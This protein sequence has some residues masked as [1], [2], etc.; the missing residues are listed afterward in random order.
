MVAEL[1]IYR[2]NLARDLCDIISSLGDED[3]DLKIKLIR[4]RLEEVVSDLGNDEAQTMFQNIKVYF[5]VT[6][7]Y[8]EENA[9][10]S[11]YEP[12][13]EAILE[14]I[15]LGRLVSLLIKKSHDLTEEEKRVI[16]STL[17]D[18]G[19]SCEIIRE[20][21]SQNIERY[22][23]DEIGLNR[24]NHTD[25][26]DYRNHNANVEYTSNISNNEQLMNVDA[27]CL[28]VVSNLSDES[29][30]FLAARSLEFLNM[31]IQ[32]FSAI[33]DFFSYY[34]IVQ[35][36]P[37]YNDT[38]VEYVKK[39]KMADP[40]NFAAQLEEYFL[41]QSNYIG[42][43]S[44]TIRKIPEIISQSYSKIFSPDSIE[45]DVIITHQKKMNEKRLKFE[46]WE[47]YMNL[48]NRNKVFSMDGSFWSDNA[49]VD[50]LNELNIQTS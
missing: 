18:A 37:K 45:T 32:N 13:I 23:Q 27:G 33:H 26:P 40:S 28:E 29:R 16:A 47:Y 35:Y 36:V 44:N 21:P 42:G 19:I 46:C 6:Q 17:T 30:N 2:E 3:Y 8:I 34:T 48:W 7:I 31:T 43:W 5:P 25:D 1:E 38:A 20:V 15:E 49:L 22:E 11:H 39:I 24:K 10:E 9:V 50:V 41:H 14:D 12:D 4:Q